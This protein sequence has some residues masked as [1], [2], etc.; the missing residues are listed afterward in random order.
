[1]I[2]KEIDLS[3]L[4]L[5]RKYLFPRGPS[6]EESGVLAAKRLASLHDESNFATEILEIIEWKFN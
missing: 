1:M 6:D 4:C 3:I 2:S 5:P